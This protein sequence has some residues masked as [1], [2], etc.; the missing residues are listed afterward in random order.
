[1]FLY[2]S[3]PRKPFC[4]A[5]AWL[6]SSSHGAWLAPV[7]QVPRTSGLLWGD[8]D[9]KTGEEGHQA[10]VSWDFL[11][12]KRSQPCGASGCLVSCW[13]LLVRKLSWLPLPCTLPSV[14]LVPLELRKMDW[15]ARSEK[16]ASLSKWSATPKPDFQGGMWRHF[17]KDFQMQLAAFP[18]SHLPLPPQAEA[19]WIFWETMWMKFLYH[20]SRKAD[21]GQ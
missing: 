7:Y 2:H 1:M 3:A 17:R 14:H 4:W 15:S 16:F 12:P 21:L 10:S 19:A 18:P 11:E 9:L 6:S 5:R 20:N 13:R 8:P